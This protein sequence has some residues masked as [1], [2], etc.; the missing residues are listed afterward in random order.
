MNNQQTLKGG[1]I[2]NP[3]II[4][5]LWLR[6]PWCLRKLIHQTS[7][8]AMNYL[9][10]WTI[11]TSKWLFDLGLVWWDLLDMNQPW[12]CSK[13]VCLYCNPFHPWR[14][15]LHKCHSS[16]W[17][18]HV[19]YYRTCMASSAE[20]KSLLEVPKYVI[21]TRPHCPK[22]IKFTCYTHA[23]SCNIESS[24]ATIATQLPKVD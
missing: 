10:A 24:I 22:L 20:N 4:I 19:G 2:W 5:L 23:R 12:T 15:A 3:N 16:P 9:I 13:R 7:D 1:W 6:D 14:M 17:V 11:V 18:L 8:N 21:N